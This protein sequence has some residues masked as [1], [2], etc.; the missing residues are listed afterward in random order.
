MKI[1]VKKLIRDEEGQALVLALILLVVGGLIA[2]SLLGYMGTGL[3]TGQVYENKMYELYAA[4]AGIEDALCQ[5]KNDQ[6]PILFPNPPAPPDCYDEY[7]YSTPWSYDLHDPVNDKD[8]H[9]TIENVW[10]PMGIDPPDAATARQ[11]IEEGELIIAGGASNPEASTYEIKISYLQGCEGPGGA[12]VKTIGIWLPPGFEYVEGSSDLEEDSEQSCYSVPNVVPHKGSCAV[13]WDFVSPVTVSGFPESFTFQYW[14]SPGQIPGA[15]VSWI[16]TTE[17]YTWDAD[18][19]VYK[20]LSVAG[21][22]EI[23]TY[24]TKGEIRELGSAISGDYCAIGSS[25]I[26][27]SSTDKYRNRLYR[28]S[29]ATIATDEYGISGIPSDATVE[30]AFLY[31][32]GW[33]DFHYRYRSSSSWRWGEVDA[34]MYPD[35]PTPENLATLVEQEAKVN[36]VS[37]S[38]GNNVREVPATNWQVAPLTGATSLIGTWSYCCFADVTALVKEDIQAGEIPPNSAAKYTLSHSSAVIN[39]PR[40]ETSYY[41]YNFYDTSGGTGYPLGSPALGT[42]ASSESD[43]RDQSAYAGWSLII[44]YSSP[45]T[46]GHQLYLYDIESPGFLFTNTWIHENGTANPDFDGDGNPGGH[47]SGFLAPEPIAG[48]DIAAKLT[49]FV[50]E[51]DNFIDEDQLKVNGY[52]MSNDESPSDNV[53]NSRSPGLAVPGVDIDTFYIDW[54]DGI[55]NPTDTSAQVD[56]PAVSHGSGSDGFN[57]VYIIISFRSDI[58]SGGIMGYLIR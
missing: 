6:L 39:Q 41:Y 31:W 1:G 10:M 11:I 34:L 56:L 38:I 44:I 24:T 22:T 36:R 26:G 9:V 14:G 35:N 13:V 58:T 28:D 32:T 18:V 53:W 20:I 57:L 7:D 16:V 15:A 2:A 51:G 48:E 50:G 40:P 46:K 27:Y 4:D 37:F 19:K 43:L 47:I 12:K 29:E 17:G 54:D 55:I 42:P 52:V 3:I 45:E 49:V 30:A 8:V 21:S 33:I 25:L 23:E 5:I